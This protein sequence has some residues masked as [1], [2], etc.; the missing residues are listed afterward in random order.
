[1]AVAKSQSY[2]VDNR[3]LQAQGV[4]DDA[5][6]QRFLRDYLNARTMA[7]KFPTT[8]ERQGDDRFVFA[9]QSGTIPVGALPSAPRGSA[10]IGNTDG[11]IVYR[12]T[13]RAKPS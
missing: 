6:G 8:Q 1:M 7:G 12:N 4:S 5:A 9:A 10:S 11:R 13:F 3:Y 2:T